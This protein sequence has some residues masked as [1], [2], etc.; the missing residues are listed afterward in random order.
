M[1]W[2]CWGASVTPKQ[3]NAE[4]T[5]WIPWVFEAGCRRF[6]SCEFPLKQFISTRFNRVSRNALNR[7]HLK[8][9]QLQARAI[10][11]LQTGALLFVFNDLQG[12]HLMQKQVLSRGHL[13]YFQ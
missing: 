10:C 4:Q 12:E 9:R 8:V 3:Q 2:K 13:L 6:C 7:K 1:W 5:P 11:D